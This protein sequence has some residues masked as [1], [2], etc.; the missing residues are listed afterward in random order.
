MSPLQ[1]RFV[2][3]RALVFLLGAASMATA[4]EQPMTTGDRVRERVLR[5]T[6]FL[7]TM[8]PGV[9]EENNITLHFRPKFGDM[10]DE[11][12]IRFPVE[13]RY[14]YTDHLELQ[15]GIVPFTPNPFNTG[16]DHR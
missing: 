14:G 7:D 4:A 2:H 10:R 12:Y 13:L 3:V 1:P 16:R 15:A 11:E 6:D 5:M 9:L 8:L